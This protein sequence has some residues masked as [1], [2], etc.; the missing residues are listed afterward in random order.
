MLSGGWEYDSHG[1]EFAEESEPATVVLC[2]G[3][4]IRRISESP[5][6]TTP[7]SATVWLAHD[8]HPQGGNR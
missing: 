8:T 6:A 1:I 5:T 4:G 2:D 3:F 7:K